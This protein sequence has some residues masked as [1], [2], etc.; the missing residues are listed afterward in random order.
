MGDLVLTQTTNS[1]SFTEPK[2]KATPPDEVSPTS[3]KCNIHNS[4]LTPPKKPSSLIFFEAF[5]ARC[6]FRK[7]RTYN[8]YVPRSCTNKGHQLMFEF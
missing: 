3:T 1:I 5:N 2:S 6:Y 7:T 4:Y 8:Q